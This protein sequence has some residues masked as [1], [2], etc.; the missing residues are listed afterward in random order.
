VGSEQQQRLALA[1][2]EK[3]VDLCSRLLMTRLGQLLLLV[4]AW[5]AGATGAGQVRSKETPDWAG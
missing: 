1:S 2:H 3:L 5:Q 4:R